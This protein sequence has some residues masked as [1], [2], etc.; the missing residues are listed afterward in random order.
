MSFQIVDVTLITSERTELSM[1]SA[2]N[3]FSEKK[4]ATLEQIA[5][6]NLLRTVTT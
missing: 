4:L 1:P 3:D 5:H 2:F 6:T